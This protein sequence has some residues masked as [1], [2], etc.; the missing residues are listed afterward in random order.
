[1]LER[2]VWLFQEVRLDANVVNGD[3]DDE[4]QSKQK[5]SE[6]ALSLVFDCRNWSMYA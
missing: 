4:R 3:A 6:L 5:G 2:N 1:V